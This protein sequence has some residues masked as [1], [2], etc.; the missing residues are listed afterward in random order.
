MQSCVLAFLKVVFGGGGVEVV[1]CDFI[2]VRAR[3]EVLA[4]E[5]RKIGVFKKI[6]S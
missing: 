5:Y 6:Q 2:K 3:A 4:S 1:D